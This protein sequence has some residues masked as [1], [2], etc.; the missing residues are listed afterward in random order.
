MKVGISRRDGNGGDRIDADYSYE[1]V[2]KTMESIIAPYGFLILVVGGA[3]A[4][5]GFLGGC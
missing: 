2:I 4:E 3:G 1:H 5:P